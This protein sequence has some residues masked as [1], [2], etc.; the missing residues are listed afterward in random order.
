M[1][2]NVRR[3]ILSPLPS[4]SEIS[5]PK[6]HAHVWSHVTM[7]SRIPVHIVVYYDLSQ[8]SIP[9][10]PFQTISSI[11][12]SLTNPMIGGNTR[13]NLFQQPGKLI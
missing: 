11:P 3:R 2:E 9:T 7:M 12:S 5:T 13:N 1:G 8:P 10:L 4:H 6:Y